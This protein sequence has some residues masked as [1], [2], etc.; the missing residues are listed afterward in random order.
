MSMAKAN[1]NGEAGCAPQARGPCCG[2][3]LS[4]V[5]ISNLLRHSCQLALGAPTASQH[6]SPYRAVEAA[7]WAEQL[8]RPH[9]AVDGALDGDVGEPHIALHGS[10]HTPQ[11]HRAQTSNERALPAASRVP[12]SY[13]ELMQCHGGGHIPGVELC[14]HANTLSPFCAHTLETRLPC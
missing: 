7:S 4:N 6:C 13:R 2:P 9:A 3:L 11:H 5:M 12:L 10:S 14:T 8:A 1:R